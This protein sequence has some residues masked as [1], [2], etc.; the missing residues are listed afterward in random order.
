MEKVVK[1]YPFVQSSLAGSR[2]AG[3][4]VR[5][6]VCKAIEEGYKVVIDFEGI[7]LITQGFGDEVIGILVRAFGVDFVK[8]NISLTNANENIKLILNAVVSY[9]K[10]KG[11]YRKPKD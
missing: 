2:Q 1:V 4:K 6:E 10:T 5:E 7:N 8:E 9:S 3:E 11:P